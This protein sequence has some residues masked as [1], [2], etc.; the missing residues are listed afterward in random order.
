MGAENINVVQQSGFKVIRKCKCSFLNVNYQQFLPNSAQSDTK[1]GGSI[2]WIT[3]V[4]VAKVQLI[5]AML[6]ASSNDA[7]S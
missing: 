6:I 2:G 4:Q 3:A 7:S 1:A 5:A